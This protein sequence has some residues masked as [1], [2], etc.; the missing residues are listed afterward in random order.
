[1]RIAWW[2]R[3]RLH[4]RQRKRTD[5]FKRFIPLNGQISNPPP[6]RANPLIV[7]YLEQVYYKFYLFFI[8][9]LF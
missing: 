6:S 5:L 7:Y 9:N 8:I 4:V 3:R 2:I 1:M